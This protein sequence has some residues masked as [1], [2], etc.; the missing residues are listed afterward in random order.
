MQREH[1]C[2]TAEGRKAARP[3]HSVPRCLSIVS[4]ERLAQCHTSLDT[5]TLPLVAAKLQVRENPARL[6]IFK[7]GHEFG[8]EFWTHFIQV[9]APVRSDK[10]PADIMGC[11][12]SLALRVTDG[13]AVFI[14]EQLNCVCS[15]AILLLHSRV[16][17]GLHT[18]ISHLCF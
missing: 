7:F 6:L 9:F 5:A 8:F 16:A 18:R 13:T 11:A 1:P 14:C 3:A 17:A 15:H 2:R 10:M 4:S 12:A